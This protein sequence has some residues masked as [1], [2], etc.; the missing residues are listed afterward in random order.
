MIRGTD[1]WSEGTP[2]PKT[3]C[4]DGKQLS[5]GR[6]SV[7]PIWYHLCYNFK[8]SETLIKTCLSTVLSLKPFRCGGWGGNHKSWMVLPTVDFH[9]WSQLS[10]KSVTIVNPLH[11]HAP[12][13]CSSQ[14]L[15]PFFSHSIRRH[16]WQ[17]I[18]TLSK[19]IKATHTTRV[20]C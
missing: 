7:S 9:H 1:G 8:N 14:A 11:Y 2:G 13:L 12:L 10:T 16:K 19:Q 3:G 20:D 6:L 15:T 5:M 17:N 18:T 4:Q